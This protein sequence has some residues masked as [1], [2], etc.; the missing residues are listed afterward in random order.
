MQ[1]TKE[2][3]KRVFFTIYTGQAFS[4]I[5]SSAAQF[6][7]IWYL[8]I[9]TDSAL[10]LSIAA[11][12]GFLP[13]ALLG[14]FAGVW[15]DRLSRK[16]IMMGAD[17]FVALCSGVLAAV[18]LFLEPPIWLVFLI[19]FL[20]SIGSVFHGPAMMAAIPMIVPPEE[21]TR[22][23]GWGQFIQSGGLMAGPV[24]GA[25]MMSVFSL[26]GVM[27]VDVIGALM[28]VGTLCFIS[29][30]RLPKAEG[31][32]QVLGDMKQGFRALRANRP[33]MAV[34]I[35]VLISTLAYV[36]MGSLYPLMV[37]QHFHG[38]AWHSSLVEFIFA[39]GM[40]LASLVVGVFGGMKRRFLMI[41]LS[42][43][44]L[45]AA[46]FLSGLLPATWFAGFVVLT[47]IMGMSGTLFNIPYMAYVQET[48][49]PEVM[50][51]V[52]SLIT[53]AMCLAT[54]IGM[55]LAGPAAEAMG[56]DAWFGACGAFVVLTGV[57]CYL[58]T[59]KYDREP[60]P[61]AAPE[62]KEMPESAE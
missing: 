53:S 20:R 5:G 57:I 11:V 27:M 29:L 15:V 54:P 13:Q 45:G 37:S 25:A 31:K 58:V 10:V 32:V 6:A 33:L 36:P 2:H 35:P 49:A 19:L 60:L 46:S 7:I 56:I 23:G 22:A 48:I 38:T 42:L 17:S 21:L 1:V 4:I 30:P 43:G 52:I 14:P 47:A 39:G 61:S 41:S 26:A 28:A 8:T 44:M 9:R 12:A 34:T 59:R 55:F 51:K 18:C 50:G 16:A 62:E 40:L 24:I 3:W